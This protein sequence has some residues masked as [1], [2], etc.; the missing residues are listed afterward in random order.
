MLDLS[1]FAVL[2]S[3]TCVSLQTLLQLVISR[4]TVALGSIG[5][6]FSL[7]LTCLV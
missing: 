7:F 4:A 1:S 5:F 2:S 3:N 6:L